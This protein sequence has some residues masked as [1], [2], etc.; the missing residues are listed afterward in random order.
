MLHKVAGIT[1]PVKPAHLPSLRCEADLPEL[2]E[3]GPLIA[4]GRM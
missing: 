2:Q 3:I 1:Y 4:A